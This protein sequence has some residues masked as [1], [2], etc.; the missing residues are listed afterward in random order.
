MKMKISDQ[1]NVFII[2]FNQY[3]PQ[4]PVLWPLKIPLHLRSTTIKNGVRQSESELTLH[5]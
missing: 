1:L 3:L 4:A 5:S 2:F